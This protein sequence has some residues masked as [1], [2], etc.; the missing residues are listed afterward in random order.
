MKVVPLLVCLGVAGLLGY[1]WH[2]SEVRHTAETA[3]AQRSRDSLVVAVASEHAERVAQYTR[4]SVEAARKLARRDAELRHARLRADSLQTVL[5]PLLDSL[6]AMLPDTMSAFVS[7]LLAAWRAQGEAWQAE[8]AQADTSIAA[9]VA[10]ITELEAGYATDL[11][12]CDSQVAEAM[13][14]LDR[15]LKRT[16]PGLLVR[17]YRVLPL[18]AGAYLLGRL[19]R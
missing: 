17:V 7:R 8:R 9:Y 6:G 16:T 4:D 18:A 1:G 3:L 5:A 12:E 15:A 11:A 2:R 13:R 10:R 19:T 14:Q